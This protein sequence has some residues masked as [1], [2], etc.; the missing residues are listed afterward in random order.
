MKIV[1][2]NHSDVKGGASVVTLRLLDALSEIPEAE[3]S[4]LTV[5][6]ASGRAGVHLAGSALSRKSAFLRE[7]LDIFLHNGLNRADLFKASAASAGLPLSR[8]P[9]VRE[10]DIVVLNWVNQGM[11]SLS[12][13]GRMARAGKKIVWTMH[14]MWPMTGICHHAGECPRYKDECRDCPL[15]SRH[16]GSGKDLSTRVFRQKAELYAHAGIHFVAVSRWLAG[17]ARESALLGDKPVEVIPNAFPVEEFAAAPTMTASQLGIPA[18][19]KIILMGAARID[20]PVKGLGYAIDALNRVTDKD[21]VAVF[22]GDLRNPR[23]LDSL[24]LPH[25]LLGRIDSPEALRSLYARSRVVLSSSLYETLPGTLVEGQAAGCFP[26][27]FDRGG[28]A[29]IIVSPA[30]GFLAPFPDTEALARGIE[31]GLRCEPDVAA[32]RESV[33]GRFSSESV[34]LKYLKLFKTIL[35]KQ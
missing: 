12:E 5:H 6:A 24:R 26:V 16:F 31:K 18:D 7:H 29:D 9:L 30:T 22:F 3:V 32:L 33:A 11:L 13:I 28:Q 8:H 35:H 20:D 21:A 23:A 14:D 2:L 4:M 34:A 1:L 19:K 27:S 15:V 25:I 10:A 17:K